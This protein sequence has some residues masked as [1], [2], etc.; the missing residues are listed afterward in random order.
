MC[1][2]PCFEG[3]HCNANT[4]QKTRDLEN[5]VE[6]NA[7][8]GAKCRLDSFSGRR[9]RGYLKFPSLGGPHTGEKIKRHPL[10]GFQEGGRSWPWM[11]RA[12]D[13]CEAY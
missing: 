1:K 6:Y 4:L 10:G 13:G 12:A 2:L 7:D 8:N 5:F 11:A 9:R 3:K